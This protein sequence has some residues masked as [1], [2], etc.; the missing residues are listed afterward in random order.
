MPYDLEVEIRQCEEDLIHKGASA[1][2]VFCITSLTTEAPILLY[3]INPKRSFISIHTREP[4]VYRQDIKSLI[5]ATHTN[6]S[7]KPPNSTYGFLDTINSNPTALSLITHATR[8]PSPPLTSPFQA[9]WTPS[10]FQNFFSLYICKNPNEI[11]PGQGHFTDFAFLVLS[12]FTISSPSYPVILCSD[13]PDSYE[14]EDLPPVLKTREMTFEDAV[15]S[16]DSYEFCVECIS[17]YGLDRVMNQ[18]PPAVLA[19]AG[20]L[21]EAFEVKSLT[22]M[23]CAKNGFK[24]IRQ[25]EEDLRRDGKE[26]DCRTRSRG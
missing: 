26:G 25:W 22:L 8:H 6:N 3:I 9:S 24:A 20:L 5:L 17:E 1:I 15:V 14:L 7:S 19:N 16:F 21:L 11:G 10:D 12:S 13:A 4:C 2:P 23:K 18:Q